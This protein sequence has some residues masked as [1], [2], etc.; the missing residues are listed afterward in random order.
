MNISKS[1]QMQFVAAAH[2][3]EG[4]VLK[5]GLTWNK[6]KSHRVWVGT[7][8]P[9]VSIEEQRDLEP[10]KNVNKNCV[11]LMSSPMQSAK[12]NELTGIR[13]ATAITVWGKEM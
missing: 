12:S 8:R 6:G 13:I 4:Q 1:L 5:D 7:R 2:L 9:I 3:E 11:K 10:I